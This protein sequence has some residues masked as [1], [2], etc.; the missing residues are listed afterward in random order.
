MPNDA[1]KEDISRPKNLGRLNVSNSI[2]LDAGSPIPLQYGADTFAYSVTGKRYIPFIGGDDNLPSLLLEARLISTTHNS[3]ISVITESSIGNGLRANVDINKELKQW[4]ES[5]NNNNQS[6]DDLLKSCIDGERSMG[7]QFIEVVRGKIGSTR[8][9][10]IYTHSILYCRLG[11]INEQTGHPTTVIISKSFAKKGYTPESKIKK[12]I[13]LYN[14]NALKDTDN[15]VK[16]GNEERTMLHFKN[17]I[18]GVDYYGMPAS[19]SS[20]R[21]QVL[22][23][24]AAQY[25]I[26]MFENNMVLS[27]ALIL[28]SAMTQEE[29]ALNA[30]TI[31]ETHTGDGRQGRIAIISSEGGIEDFEFV[32]YETQKEG[33]FI[34]FDKRVE[35]K[36]ISANGWA[37]EFTTSDSSLLGKG[38]QYLRSLWDLKSATTLSPLRKRIIK[39][40]VKPI[41]KI[42]A[43]WFNKNDVLE[44]E[45]AFEET[46]PFSFLGELNP[47]DFMKINEARQMAGME[48]DAANGNKYISETKTK[49][50]ASV[51]G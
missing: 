7:N 15:W 32:K 51:Q 12:E 20:L 22:E 6:F 27:G 23:G 47:S 33:S 16:E 13:P 34:E 38:G 1:N 4:F 37:K 49:N 26:D 48:E 43:D 5:V 39:K 36:I 30:Q 25:N 8:Y 11:K 42:W 50:Q 2:K 24:K 28:K 40:V 46:M 35:E 21:Y 41:I 3:C 29:A 14:P 18:S 9:L 19:I 17:E 45:W 31:L 10:K 44:Y